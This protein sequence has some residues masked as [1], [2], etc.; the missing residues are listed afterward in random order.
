M[1]YPE[2]SKNGLQGVGGQ[3]PFEKVF[4]NEKDVRNDKIHVVVHGAS[5]VYE[6]YVFGNTFP[7]KDAIKGIKRVKLTW[8]HNM[9]RWGWMY[10]NESEKM[11]PEETYEV[12]KAINE[13]AKSKD[14]EVMV[15][16]NVGTFG[17]FKVGKV[18]VY[19]DFIKWWENP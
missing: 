17:T 16:V 13:A 14:I 2:V 11:T 1:E 7:V 15:Y 6:L 12:L 4:L 3:T 8:D 5:K 18:E 9:K 10:R 19:P